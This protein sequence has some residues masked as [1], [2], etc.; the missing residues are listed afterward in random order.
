MQFKQI[1][2]NFTFYDIFKDWKQELT[3]PL[4]MRQWAS[5]WHAGY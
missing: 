4:S 5:A 2:F 3:T 1:N